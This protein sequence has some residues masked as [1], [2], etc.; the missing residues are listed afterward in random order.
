M[1]TLLVAAAIALA[2]AGPTALS[3][4]EP[5]PPV[6]R[7]EV[8]RAFEGYLFSVASG[9]APR[10]QFLARDRHM[11]LVLV[12]E[13][14]LTWSAEEQFAVSYHWLS[15][16]GEMLRMN[17]A[18]TALPRP[19]P[20]GDRIELEVLVRPL[21]TTGLYRLQWDM[22]QEN[23][24]W[25]SQLD[26]TPEP[27]QAVLILPRIEYFI[28]FLAP[29]AAA[30]LGLVTVELA[31]HRL[32]GWLWLA[33]FAD[34]FWCGTVLIGKPFL[35]FREAP[36][37]FQP[38][39]HWIA[40]AWVALFLLLLYPW[41]QRLRPWLSWGLAAFS[42][43]FLWG[44][45]LYFRFF[46]DLASTAVLFAARQTGELMESALFL[47]QPR[48]W[49]LAADLPLGLLLALRTAGLAGLRPPRSRAARYLPL[50]VLMAA[51]LPGLWAGRPRPSDEPPPIRKTQ[52]PM[53]GVQKRG[54]W[55]YQV[56][57]LVAQLRRSLIRPPLTEG[58]LDEI[59]AW[60]GERAPGR[61]GV[62]PWFG[63]AEGKNLLV[64]QIESMQQFVLGMELEGQE[65]TP[66]LNR[67]AAS[68]LAFPRM[69]D[70]TSKGRS[71]DGDF[72]NF[73]SLLPVAD[74]IAYEYPSNRYSTL[75][76]ALAARGYATLSAI[77]FSRTFWN[78]QFT[79]PAYGFEMV[80]F[81][82]DFEAGER[83]G[84][85]LNDRDFLRQMAPRLQRLPRPFFAWLTTL[86]L[87]YPFSDFPEELKDLDLGS[88]EGT[89]LG[90]YLHA[91]NLFDRAFGELYRELEASGLLEETLL[92]LWG[93]HDS[94]LHHRPEFDQVL[95][96]R[97][98]RL[99]RFLADRVP[100]LIRVPGPDPPAGS[101][102]M[103][104]GHTD[105]APT[106]MALLGID[107]AGY[108]FVGRN[109]LGEPEPVPVPHPGGNWE[110]LAHAFLE[111]GSEEEPPACWSLES[112]RAVAPEIC[113]ER[114][115]WVR[116][117]IEISDA[118]LV[119]DLQQRV[120]DALQQQMATARSREPEAP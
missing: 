119:Y 34:L 68:E 36:L 9:R 30:L 54:L 28:G 105:I 107:P 60:F 118:M 89:S 87:H 106:L 5:E 1:G 63:R 2:A 66:E 92:A 21:P 32:R 49:Q 55:G 79:H 26:P 14:S 35:L 95:G 77:P 67:F 90:N 47:S 64:I 8:R 13:G 3:G 117:L 43:F 84:W 12:N 39:A 80:W 113:A 71:S 16:E 86:S 69:R 82:E 94:G 58:D 93:D 83:I 100:L 37:R 50:G 27:A 73:T 61:A 23:V 65:I 103:P 76:G 44:D 33:A 78:R 24:T 52:P 96:I 98:T 116:R 25:F 101:I 81:R 88:W 22:V 109:L 40:L 120:T 99:Q 10:I 15:A 97:P 7:E 111:G 108:A 46:D 6:L 42:A 31:R 114:N 51:L 110:D 85:G 75:T 48:D 29:L 11:R 45:L 70:Q 56:L 104:V 4:Q 62:G 38:G 91:M 41:P 20:P 57:D 53:R 72:V 112:E 59:V 102:E 17:G 115:R 18:R 19:V 74:S